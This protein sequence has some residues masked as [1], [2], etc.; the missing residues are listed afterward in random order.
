MA[1]SAPVG[2]GELS[3]GI[4]LPPGGSVGLLSLPGIA[5]GVVLAS[6][7]ASGAPLALVLAVSASTEPVMSGR[8]F[9]ATRR[10][11]GRRGTGG[12]PL[13]SG[14]LNICC[15]HDIAAPGGWV[16]SGA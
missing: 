10:A 15:A 6:L 11:T 8:S 3:V 14:K 4:R 2:S 7:L 16:A 13:P 9:S 1:R 5:V 12:E